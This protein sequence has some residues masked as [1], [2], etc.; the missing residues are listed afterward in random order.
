VVVALIDDH[1]IL[2]FLVAREPVPGRFATTCG[3]WWRLTS[4]FAGSR[5]GALTGRLQDLDERIVRMVLQTVRS[6][7]DH[8]EIVDL[9]LLIPAMG[10]LAEDHRV[11]LLAAEAVAAAA[12]LDTSIEVETDVP[13]IRD[14]AE[15]IQIV[16][17]VV[18]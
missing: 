6:L 11:D 16:Y 2:S 7:P 4:A 12:Y 9:R 17:R 1:R 5:R 13:Q 8:F 10:A 3:W 14:A 15:A 18:A